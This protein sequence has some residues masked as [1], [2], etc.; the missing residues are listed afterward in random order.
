MYTTY[1]REINSMLCYTVVGIKMIRVYSKM[2]TN[3]KNGYHFYIS[4]IIV[5]ITIIKAYQK[6]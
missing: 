4:A 2:G 6:R 1:F 3:R 5:L